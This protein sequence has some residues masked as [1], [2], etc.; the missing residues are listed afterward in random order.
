MGR[1]QEMLDDGVNCFSCQR[2][3][4]FYRPQLPFLGPFAHTLASAALALHWAFLPQSSLSLRW[5]WLHLLSIP[6]IDLRWEG[7]S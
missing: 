3:E 2:P 7:G 6:I 5:V 4:R 1:W